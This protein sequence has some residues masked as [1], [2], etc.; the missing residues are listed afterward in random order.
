MG[1][2]RYVNGQRIGG[3]PT[4]ILRP[5]GPKRVATG[6]V[7]M[8]SAP[9]TA[10]SSAGLDASVQ[11]TKSFTLG[12]TGQAGG[13]N[14]FKSGPVKATNTGA[15]K[16]TMT[17]KVK[18]ANGTPTLTAAGVAVAAV[19]GNPRASVTKIT[20]TKALPIGVKG[21]I[22]VIANPAVGKIGTIQGATLSVNELT[23]V[24]F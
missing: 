4:N 19:T 8:T 12:L 6:A 22:V 10:F 24:L 16:V 13:R 18:T 17:V 11:I 20:N 14:F 15:N 23:T 21:T 2:V 9:V 3:V 5:Q 1:R 7:S